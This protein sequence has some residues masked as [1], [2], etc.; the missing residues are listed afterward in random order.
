MY[1]LASDFTVTSTALDIDRLTV[2]NNGQMFT[3]STT[4]YTNTLSFQIK[5]QVGS[6]TI[7]SGSPRFVVYGNPT[8]SSTFVCL[9]NGVS[10]APTSEF[11][12]PSSFLQCTISVIDYFGDTTSALPSDFYV[13]A[14][15]AVDALT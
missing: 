9:G 2:V 10:F 1:A 14:S 3:F 6:T 7:K 5:A 4:P 13:N 11:V 12:E 15:T 8:T